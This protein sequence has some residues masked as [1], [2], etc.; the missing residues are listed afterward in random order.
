MSQSLNPAQG[1]RCRP[2]ARALTAQLP[3]VAVLLAGC[4]A[5]PG[6]APGP[7][8]DV[9]DK[10]KPGPN[11]KLALV[12]PARGVQVYEC[13][14]KASAVGYEWAL[15]APEAELLDAKGRRIGRHYVGPH[16]EAN[17]GSR[18]AGTVKERADAP[19]AGAIPWLLL[20]ARSVGAEG[21]FSRVSSIQRI[22]TVGGVAPPASA[23]TASRAGTPARVPYTADYYFFTP[24]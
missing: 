13:R 17:D 2:G 10:L 12:V 9:P 3:V 14:L 5:L 22:H 24:R 23:C 15:V 1:P 18:I 11:E 7:A 16:W 20:A 4:A 21:A 6:T 19:A 8:P